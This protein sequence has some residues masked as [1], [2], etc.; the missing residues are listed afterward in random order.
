MPW[1]LRITLTLS[2]VIVGGLLA[3]ESQKKPSAKER[4]APDKPFDDAF[5]AKRRSIEAEPKTGG[6]EPWEGVFYD[7]SATLGFA[8]G[9]M[10]SRK[11]GYISTTKTY[12]WGTV[13]AKGD[14]ITLVSEAPGKPWG[15]MPLEYVVVPWS[16]KVY[17]VEPDRIIAFCNAVNSGYLGRYPPDGRFLLRVEDFDKKPAGLPRIPEKYKEYLLQQPI[18]GSIVKGNWEKGD[19]AV[20]GQKCLRSGFAWTLDVGKKHGVRTGMEFYS[21]QEQHPDVFSSFCVISVTESQSE[22][23]EYSFT[24]GAMSQAKTG[25]RMTT[26][27]REFK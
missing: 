18:T 11:I 16:T 22:L 23:L 5:H 21:V 8:R 3:A 10:I 19:V 25:M 2:L 26:R 17:L 20:L 27:N 13:E 24:K 12:D 1:I 4:D 9:W 14:R 7:G 6:R 15:L